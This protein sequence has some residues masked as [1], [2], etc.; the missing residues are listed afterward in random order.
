MR[1]VFHVSEAAGG[2]RD[3]VAF[4]FGESGLWVVFKLMELP[5]SERFRGL[6][7]GGSFPCGLFASQRPD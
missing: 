7:D 4:G 6:K 5:A 2:V 3:G 1:R